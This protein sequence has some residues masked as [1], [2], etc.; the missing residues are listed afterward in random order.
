[1]SS[2]RESKQSL[3]DLNERDEEDIARALTPTTPTRQ[4]TNNRPRSDS[5]TTARADSTSS[6]Y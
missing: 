2:N 1:M 5:S 4:I 3:A 6:Q